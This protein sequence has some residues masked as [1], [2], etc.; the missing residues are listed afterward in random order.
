LKFLEQRGVNEASANAYLDSVSQQRG[1]TR[2]ELV[3]ELHQNLIQKDEEQKN[4]SQEYYDG[5]LM[6]EVTKKDVWDKA[7]QDA[8]GQAAYFNANK[9]NYTWDA[10]RFC[11]IV[12]HAKDA[13]TLAKAKKVLKGVKEADWA[14]TIVSNLNTDSVKV[15][16][17]E[18]G[19]FKQGDNAFVDKEVFKQKAEVKAKKDYPAWMVYGKKVKAPRTY[20]DVRGQVIIDYQNACEKTW[21]ES[22]HKKFPVEVY[23]DV[24]KTVNQH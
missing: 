24:V 12:I 11:G 21:V 13:G 20:T 16:R 6:Y 17:V 9:K 4:L 22:L 14:K 10:P 3:E 18:R 1:M 5:T 8:A 23:K 7:Q 19:I 15:V 2:A